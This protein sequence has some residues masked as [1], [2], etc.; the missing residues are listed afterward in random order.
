MKICP[1]CNS[2]WADF[3]E[4]CFNDGTP[5]QEVVA[6]AAPTSAA[7]NLTDRVVTPLLPAVGES[8]EEAERPTVLDPAK[9][10]GAQ[11]VR[12]ADAEMMP[13]PPRVVRPEDPT[14]PPTAE[15]QEA[16]VPVHRE[17]PEGVGEALPEVDDQTSPEGDLSGL[18][19]MGNI[20][21]N[22]T[23][24]PFDDDGSASTQSV[25][26]QA[27]ERAAASPAA[28]PPK[29]E[30]PPEPRP[31]PSPAP[32]SGGVGVAVAVGTAA[33]VV[34]LGAG[35]LFWWWSSRDLPPP[36]A[37]VTAPAA[38]APAPVEVPPA[39]VE[40]PPA[41]AEVPPAPSGDP[42]VPPPVAAPPAPAEGTAAPA[43]AAAPAVSTGILKLTPDPASARVWVDGKALGAGPQSVSLPYGKHEVRLEADGYKAEK[44]E[45]QISGPQLLIPRKMTATGTPVEVELS[46]VDTAP[47]T[48]KVDGGEVVTLPAKLTI[49]TGNRS[50][51]LTSG[52]GVMCTVYRTIR[53]PEGASALQLPLSCPR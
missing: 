7:P 48:V 34:I 41:P 8:T 50:F 46:C 24:L 28:P 16:A 38:A 15:P 33:L 10:G 44:F 12:P 31:A 11:T 25:F 4:L 6:A 40:V 32:A 26:P 35:G 9:A 23:L 52:G 43:S 39:P 22:Q 17:L 37:P 29:R 27:G 51:R 19:A 42:A 36:P 3:V 5:L 14:L 2:T 45:V 18:R 1:T 20:S 47:C 53:V 13:E 30:V 21:P 49:A